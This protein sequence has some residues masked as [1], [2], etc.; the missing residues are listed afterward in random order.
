[1]S[2]SAE[3]RPELLDVL[4][5]GPVGVT[6]PDEVARQKERML[7]WLEEQ[8]VALPARRF[9]LAHRAR[10][11]RIAGVTGAVLAAAA[12]LVLALS[13][14][15]DATDEPDRI[16]SAPAVV[17]SQTGAFGT[18]VS[19]RLH[20]GRVDF[21]DGER[22]ELSGRVETGREGAALQASRGYQLELGPSSALTFE[23]D[24]SQKEGGMESQLRLH[25]GHAKLSVLPRPSGSTLRIVTGDALV[26][27]VKS[28]F[29]IEARQGKSCV[30]VTEGS[31]NVR[32]GSVEEVVEAGQSSGCAGSR[33]ED[34]GAALPRTSNKPIQAQRTTLSQENALL[35]RALAAESR[36]DNKTA[37][38]AYSELLTKYPRSSFAQDAKAGL[39]RLERS[40]K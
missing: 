6:S 39:G 36:G 28:A 37:R 7:P 34:L 3:E 35:S 25:Q 32:R 31:V 9:E 13:F 40:I 21:V 17:G 33:D 27:V 12:A 23:T 18:I 4:G 30:R 2:D 15:G 10:T 11:R 29:S 14:D 16:A 38:K 8:V 1:M 22:L 24:E 5:A 26:T 19:G 20:F